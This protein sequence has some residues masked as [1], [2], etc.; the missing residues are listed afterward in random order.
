MSARFAA[1]FAAIP[2]PAAQQDDEG[3]MPQP[4]VQQDGESAAGLQKGRVGNAAD[5]GGFAVLP[6]YGLRKEQRFSLFAGG[7]HRGQNHM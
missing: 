4:A 6:V 5:D 2:Q 7:Q 1:V 3:A